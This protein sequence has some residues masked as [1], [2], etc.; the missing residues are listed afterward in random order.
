MKTPYDKKWI[1]RLFK[2]LHILMNIRYLTKMDHYIEQL[3]EIWQVVEH[4][5]TLP[6]KSFTLI[7]TCEWVNSRTGDNL[8][9]RCHVF[10]K[11]YLAELKCRNMTDYYT[12]RYDVI[13]KTMRTT[14]CHTSCLGIAGGNNH[15]TIRFYLRQFRIW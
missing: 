12:K 5:D 11:T 1:C 7:C 9:H 2:K 3:W 14:F 6:Y 15:E 4:D 8:R 10:R 13:F